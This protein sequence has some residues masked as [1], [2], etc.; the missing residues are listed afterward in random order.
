MIVIDVGNTNLHFA[1]EKNG[2]FK[3]EFRLQTS[4]ANIKTISAAI[5]KYPD[6]KIIICS[7][8]PKITKIFRQLRQKR[9]K[10]RKRIYI[11]G[12]NI[13]IPIKSF[14]DKK[15]IGMD[16]LVGA[17][18]GGVMY[19]RARLIIDFGTAITFD[20]L[21]KKGEYEGGFILPG[22]GST[23]EVF[24]SCALLPDKISL[25]I[26]KK[27]AGEAKSKVR[28]PRTT[29]ESIL[30]GVEDGFSL[31]INSLV[32][33]YKKSFGLSKKDIIVITGGESAIIKPYLTFPY[34]FEPLLVLK[35]LSML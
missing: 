11:V 31:M 9:E 30:K 8:V 13:K 32:K 23:L 1:W 27:N 3:K 2:K 4:K 6:E 33:K 28:I 18:A 19:S 15:S 22:I 10:F 20:F 24:S 17:F 35:G 26:S 21:S 5:H 12:E 29:K 14:Y 25:R 16:R 7:V 34:V